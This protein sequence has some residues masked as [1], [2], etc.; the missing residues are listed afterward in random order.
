MA[1]TPAWM[2]QNDTGHAP[3]PSAPPP[4]DAPRL[5]IPPG[6]IMAQLRRS[7]VTLAL[8]LLGGLLLGGGVSAVFK[9][10]YVAT[11]ELLVDPRGLQLVDRDLT[12]RSQATD[13]MMAVVESYARIITSD[14][15]LNTV[16]EKERL[17]GDAEFA[18]GTGLATMLK[19]ALFGGSGSRSDD[20]NKVLDNLRQAVTAKRAERSYVLEIS[21]KT[22]SPDKSARLANAVSAAFVEAEIAARAESAR[23]ASGALSARLD[24]LRQRVLSAENAVEA[25]KAKNNIVGVGGRL[26]GEQQLSDLT[27]QLASA[28]ARTSELKAR[29][30]QVERA[31]RNGGDSE[32]TAEAV[33]SQTIGLL[34]GQQADLK[35]Q[36]NELLATLGP[37]HPNLQP[38]REQLRGVQTMI[39]EEL[40][41]I[42]RMVK[43][44]A[45]RAQ[46]NEDALAK[47]LDKMK[48]DAL[49]TS[50]S[51]VRLRELEREVDASR[52]IY[53]SF[54]KRSREI[55][56][57]EQI[58]SSNIRI[59]SP[60]LPPLKP[61][62]VQPI[63]FVI[64]GPLVGLLIGLGLVALR[65]VRQ[66][67]SGR[68]R[69]APA[70]APYGYAPQQPYA[71]QGY[72]PRQPPHG[73]APRSAY[74]P[75]PAPQQG[76]PR[77]MAYPQRGQGPVPPGPAFPRRG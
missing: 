52:A 41:R 17:D 1:Q 18:A 14:T 57:Q 36:E 56:E 72:A 63:V 37:R 4:S 60:A 7:P 20:E 65:T 27:T 45:D 47:N 73:Y 23:K 61:T 35:R 55:G 62:G 28:R 10:K 44:E 26:V 16:I 21:V 30:E 24:E 8:C 49:N 74:A 33:Q 66:I 11:A 70:Y 39:N 19:R 2:T 25:Y 54:L 38:V 5:S 43:S 48:G 58:D 75:A 53:E 22:K 15:V 46:A 77:P 71:P 9:P 29:S 32:A 50:A 76:A 69:T 67:L 31:R 68:Q 40:T 51:F 42:A 6:L 59:I 64:A 3:A 12:A 34:R 13:A